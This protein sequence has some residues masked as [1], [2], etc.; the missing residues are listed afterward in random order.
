MF[1]G[2]F[3]SFDLKNFMKEGKTYWLSTDITTRI[4]KEASIG[5]YDFLVGTYISMEVSLQKSNSAFQKWMY[6]APL[7]S[8][9]KTLFSLHS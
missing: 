4:P 6:L 1:V 5:I 9:S 8:L 2:S 7:N 3:M